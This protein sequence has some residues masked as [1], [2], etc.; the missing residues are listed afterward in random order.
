[1]TNRPPEVDG[2]ERTSIGDVRY[3]MMITEAAGLDIAGKCSPNRRAASTGRPFPLA[4]E[5]RHGTL[6]DPAQ[7][8]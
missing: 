1:M 3:T 4:G 8:S 5:T 2:H 6:V 7:R